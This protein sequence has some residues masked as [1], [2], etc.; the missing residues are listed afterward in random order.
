MIKNEPIPS[1]R[2]SAG[3]TL[4]ELMVSL[5]ILSLIAVIAGNAL[6]SGQRVWTKVDEYVSTAEKVEAVQN[7]M[8]EQIQQA[9]PVLGRT[10]PREERVMLNGNA[11]SITFVAPLPSHFG[12]YGLYRIEYRLVDGQLI[13]ARSLFQGPNDFRRNFSETTQEV[14]IDG[15]ESLQFAYL[16]SDR[17][18]RGWSSSLTDATAMPELVRIDV[19]FKDPGA[20]WQS[21]YAQPRVTSLN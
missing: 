7:L 17:D 20:K 16:R 3:F 6:V 10:T 12:R 14:L 21:I 11:D 1:A 8:R 2:S 13:F 18:H 9:L 4:V 5:A 19:E 15:V